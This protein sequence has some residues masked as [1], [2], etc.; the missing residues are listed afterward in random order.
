MLEPIEK[1]KD[2]PQKATEEAKV[3]DITKAT[4]DITSEEQPME[5]VSFDDV[6]TLTE[7]SVTPSPSGFL[8]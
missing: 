4:P 7:S 2:K 6:G 5:T 3:S 8:S 1:T